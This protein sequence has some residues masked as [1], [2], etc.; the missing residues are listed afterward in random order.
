MLPYKSM[1]TDVQTKC[2]QTHGTNNMICAE[3][4]DYVSHHNAHMFRRSACTSK[5][6]EGKPLICASLNVEATCTYLY[7]FR[8]LK[9]S[10]LLRVLSRMQ[11]P[12]SLHLVTDF[13]LV[14]CFDP[15]LEVS[16]LQITKQLKVVVH[17]TLSGIIPHSVHV[18][19]MKKRRSSTPLLYKHVCRLVP[20]RRIII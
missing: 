2:A 6:I 14:D 11:I 3:N 7:R 15:S 20:I 18:N 10:M 19:V 8:T 13:R 4:N 12:N 16:I 17:K 9:A 5:H 1:Q